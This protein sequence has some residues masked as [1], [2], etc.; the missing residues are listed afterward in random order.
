MPIT[1]K[2][3]AQ[4]NVKNPIE[5]PDLPPTL[6]SGICLKVSGLSGLFLDMQS[7]RAMFGILDVEEH[8]PCLCIQAFDIETRSL[9]DEKDIRDIEGIF[10]LDINHS[11]GRTDYEITKSTESNYDPKCSDRLL[12]FKYV[13]DWEKLYNT[14]LPKDFSH[15]KA[16]FYFNEGELYGYKL[17]C[18]N[19]KL[20]QWNLR[21]KDPEPSGELYNKFFGY[22]ADSVGVKII[23]KETDKAHLLHGE[24]ELYSFSPL[25]FYLVTLSNN[26]Q[27]TDKLTSDID[28]LYEQLVC[29]NKTM[30][31]V[32]PIR[33]DSSTV[34]PEPPA[35]CSTIVF[36]KTRSF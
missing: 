13:L 12:S 4:K 14:E 15:L 11:D 34:V 10:R 30:L 27:Q 33:T 2:K 16:R 19:G 35:L 1:K 7:S 31:K 6:W 3:A 36:S 32:V 23:I 25:K 18:H 20:T 26:C 8:Q 24:E 9:I 5:E 17:H 28:Y 21:C 22:V 29:L